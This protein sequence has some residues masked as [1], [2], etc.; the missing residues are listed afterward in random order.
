MTVKLAHLKSGENIIS[1]IQEMVVGEGDNSRVVG[2]LFGKP[3]AVLLRD[4][5]IVSKNDEET[6][7]HSFDINL[8]PWIPFTKDKKVPVPSDW[9]VTLVEPL[10]KLKSM[11]EKNVLKIGEKNDETTSTDEQSDS[12]I[13]D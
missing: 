7:K 12:D 4:F 10:D 13:S 5:E 2:Y 11:Y 3:Q 6:L 9:V 1:D 8:V